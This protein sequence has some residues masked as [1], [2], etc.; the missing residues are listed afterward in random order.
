[1]VESSQLLCH[2]LKNGTETVLRRCHSASHAVASSE[3][4]FAGKVTGTGG[5]LR[6]VP[7]PHGYK[8]L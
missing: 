8:P 2:R 3:T 4:E 1:M 6:A 5:L 7:G